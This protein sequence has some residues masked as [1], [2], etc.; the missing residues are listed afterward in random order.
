MC[1]IEDS[2]KYEAVSH[3]ETKNSMEVR[4][5]GK[6]FEVREYILCNFLLDGALHCILLFVTE[7]LIEYSLWHNS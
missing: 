4:Q 2:S 5:P 1:E 7:K 6:H 3:T